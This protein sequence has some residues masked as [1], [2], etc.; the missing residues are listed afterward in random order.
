MYRLVLRC[1]ERHTI[2]LEQQFLDRSILSI[3]SMSRTYQQEA[4]YFKYLEKLY[5]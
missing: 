5:L 2:N 1:V 3:R 4:Y